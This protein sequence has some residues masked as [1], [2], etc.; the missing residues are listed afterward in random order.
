M[1]GKTV[2][3]IDTRGALTPQAMFAELYDLAEKG[4][5]TDAVI[6]FRYAK[7][8]KSEETQE[9]DPRAGVCNVWW[10][11]SDGSIISFM[12]GVINKRINDLLYP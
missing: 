5:I 8:L 11:H 4:I 1:K 3:V 2:E 6:G 12:I 10:T 7:D 9:E